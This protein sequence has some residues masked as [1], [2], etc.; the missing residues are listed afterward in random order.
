MTSEDILG[1]RIAPYTY[2]G[3]LPPFGHG[4]T[5][6]PYFQQLRNI[7]SKIVRA[8][9]QN[10]FLLESLAKQ[11]V[12]RGFKINKKIMAVHPSAKLKVVHFKIIANAEME[13]MKATIDHYLATIPL[14]EAEFQEVYDDLNTLPSYDRRLV[15]LYLL[16]E[17]NMIMDERT[18]PLQDKLERDARERLEN[19]TD[20]QEAGPSN[21]PP[22]PQTRGR[23]AFRNRNDNAPQMRFQPRTDNT[24][25]QRFQPRNRDRTPTTDDPNYG[26]YAAPPRPQRAPRTRNP[27]QNRP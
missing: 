13:I 18:G 9:L 12:P 16:H 21:A 19:N 8:K 26:A 15:I 11:Q 6:I 1:L 20:Q 5:A 14:L 10:N 25:Q 7:M 23:D 3:K 22:P 4:V 2:E 27:W 17:K 24:P